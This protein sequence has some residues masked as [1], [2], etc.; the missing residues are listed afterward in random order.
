MS[1]SIKDAII[2]ILFIIATAIW[3]DYIEPQGDP[4][5]PKLPVVEDPNPRPESS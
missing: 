1:I 4:T 2:V 3:I 5:P